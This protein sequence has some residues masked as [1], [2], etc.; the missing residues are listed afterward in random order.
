M[1]PWR[2]LRIQ[3]EFVESFDTLVDLGPAVTIFGSARTT[4]HDPMY[5]AVVETAR[6]LSE[7]GLAIITGFCDFSR[8][9]RHP[10]PTV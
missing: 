4:E 6:L 7:A 3:G 10:G 9:I 2:V 5:Q 1:D 8:R